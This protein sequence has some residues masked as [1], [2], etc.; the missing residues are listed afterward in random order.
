MTTKPSLLLLSTLLVV[1]LIRATNVL[2]A[3]YVGSQQCEAC[4]QPQSTA[5]QGSH[6]AMA[7]RHATKASV[8]G[9]FDNVS[10]P[11]DQR[12]NRFYRKAD[13]YWVNMPDV[14]GK[15]QDYQIKYTF[16]VEP[17]QQYMVEFDDGRVQLIPY[18]WD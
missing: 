5:W 17:L 15:Q 16:G 11:A 3:E 1:I 2:A 9:N 4:H 6:H 10:F 12:I 14:D 13:Q 18:A 8:K 7:M